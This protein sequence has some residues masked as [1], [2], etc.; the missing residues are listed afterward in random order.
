MGGHLTFKEL[1]RNEV[2]PVSW[3]VWLHFKCRESPW[4]RWPYWTVQ[5]LWSVSIVAENSAQQ[6]EPQDRA[7]TLESSGFCKPRRLQG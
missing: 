6:P 5:K 7:V 1:K 3:L 2:S 4:P